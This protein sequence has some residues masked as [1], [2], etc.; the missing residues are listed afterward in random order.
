M[1]TDVNIHDGGGMMWDGKYMTLSD[2]VN[3]HHRGKIHQETVIYQMAEDS[4][5]NLTRVGETVL[6]CHGRR[7]RQPSSPPLEQQP[8]IVGSTNTPITKR[9]GNVVVFANKLCP[10]KFNYW[11]YPSGGT[12]FRALH[13]P[14]TGESV[15]FAP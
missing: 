10:Q 15:S 2:I 7:I 1:T 13:L 9:Q 8:F 3:K 11:T 14:S 5:G 4:H 12:A 6:S